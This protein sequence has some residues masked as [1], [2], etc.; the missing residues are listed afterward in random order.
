MRHNSSGTYKSQPD[1]YL[2]SLVTML[3]PYYYSSG[4]TKDQWRF[5][6]NI[7]S[8]LQPYLSRLNLSFLKCFFFLNKIENVHEGVKLKVDL[9]LDLYVVKQKTVHYLPISL[10]KKPYNFLMRPSGVSMIVQET[11]VQGDSCP[12]DFCPITQLSKETFV[13]WDF[14]PRKLLPYSMIMDNCHLD[15]SLLGQLLPW[16]IVP[17]TIVA[18]LPFFYRIHEFVKLNQK[19]K[20]I[21]PHYHRKYSAANIFTLGSILDS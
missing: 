17:F 18:T 3:R 6:Q 1:K 19:K 10:V 20:H 14:C 15:K 13:Q 7:G 16:T 21:F 12:R 2:C 8:F 11:I 5:R 9:K 4:I